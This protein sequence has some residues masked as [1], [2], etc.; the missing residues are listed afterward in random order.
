MSIPTGGA[1][2]FAKGAAPGAASGAGVSRAGADVAKN[3]KDQAAPAVGGAAN[4]AGQ[5]VGNELAQHPGP[6]S[7]LGAA[8]LAQAAAGATPAGTALKAATT[9]A[10]LGAA[11]TSAASDPDADGETVS[12]IGGEVKKAALTASLPAAGAAGQLMFAMMLLNWLKAMFFAALAAIANIIG[13]AIAV[14]MVV[15]KVLFGGAFAAGAA[16]SSF[17][18]GA[19]S[20]A[21]ATVATAAVG[22]LVAVAA[23]VSIV[24]GTGNGTAQRDGGLADC[25]AD[26]VAAS[27]STDAGTVEG[28]AAVT[29]ANAKLVYGVLSAWGMPDENIAGILGN[30]DAESGI[31]PTGVETVSGE[32]FSLGTKKKDAEDKGFDVDKVDSEYSKKFPGVDLLGIGLGQ[33]SNARNTQ[34]REYAKDPGKWATLETQLGFMISKDSGAPV[35]KNMIA[36]PVG[37]AAAA[38]VYFHNEW[39]RSADGSTSTRETAAT[40]WFT[41]MGG[42]AKNQSLADSILAQSG[43]TLSEANVNRVSTAKANCRTGKVR[44]AGLKDGGMTLDEAQ[45]FMATYKFE[46][47]SVLGAAFGGGGP[48]DCG[49][50]KADNC[51]GFSWYFMHKFTSVK[52]YASGN[53]IDTAAGIAK[54]TGRA[55]SGVPTPYSVFSQKTDAPEGHTGVILG[56]QG[57][58]AVIGEASCGS[59]HVGTRAYTRPLS[60]LTPDIFAFT[61]VSDLITVKSMS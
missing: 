56:I 36:H 31:D 15:G 17:V 23:A 42:W 59:N 34:L 18:G 48:G 54:L 6:T 60:E 33:W 26:I 30:W 11:G 39:E 25:S 2:G 1:G 19:I 45:A 24:S 61:D 44:T 27:L 57:D 21:T 41:K 3:A 4:A 37:S 58:Q 40:K 46:G 13:T 32:P 16:V 49:F 28:N 7:S 14:A 5:R 55:T 53:G 47:E 8:G 35:I 12:R 43:A 50:G 22:A 52:E 9:V 29:L 38:A 20:A 51:V 10:K